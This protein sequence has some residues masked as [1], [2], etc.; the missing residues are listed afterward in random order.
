MIYLADRSVFIHIPRTSGISLCQALASHPDL[1]TLAPSIVLGYGIGEVSR[2]TTANSLKDQLSDWNRI[3][4]VTIV[5]NPW[6]LAESTYRHFQEK[7][8]QVKAGVLPWYAPGYCDWLDMIASLSFSEF[9]V[10]RM[11]HLRHGFFTH[12]CQEW[13]TFAD[14]GVETFRMEDLD[15]EWPKL[16]DALGIP[17][18]P[19]P[20]VN[21]S[22]KSPLEWTDEA[23]EFLRSRCS[24]DFELFGYPDGP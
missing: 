19:R 8:G 7:N 22:R 12:W 24:R 4:K 10:Q 20:A 13:G 6:R 1:E 2:H 11:D 16:L 21:E 3:Q 9:I 23:V 17:H 18:V 14:L 15:L 5:R